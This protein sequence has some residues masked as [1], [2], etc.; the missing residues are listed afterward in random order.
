MRFWVKG[1]L[2][3]S[4]ANSVVTIDVQ[5]ATSDLTNVLRRPVEIASVTRNFVS[6]G[7]DS[8]CQPFAEPRGLRVTDSALG[9]DFR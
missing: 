8:R 9:V 2:P 5:V 7:A 6:C 3:Q 4:D 1:I